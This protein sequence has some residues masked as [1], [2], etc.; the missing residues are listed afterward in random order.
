MIRF[1]LY[2]LTPIMIIVEILEA[3]RYYKSNY[4]LMESS[5]VVPGSTWLEKNST[6]LLLSFSLIYFIT[7]VAESKKV[8]V[9]NS[10]LLK[11]NQYKKRISVG[12]TI[13]NPFNSLQR[14]MYIK[15]FTYFDYIML[16]MS[17]AAST[18]DINLMNFGLF[19]YCISVMAMQKTKANT[20]WVY[21]VFFI[22]LF[23]L[24]K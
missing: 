3:W 20:A 1:S 13:R 8:E 10:L 12:I 7:S 11:L 19:A 22:D 9:R 21:Y 4:M 15:F 6:A 2:L 24:V 17:L 18:V 16:V 23:T 5:R 14:F